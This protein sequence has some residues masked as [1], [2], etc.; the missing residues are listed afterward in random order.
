MRYSVY[1]QYQ[2]KEPLLVEASDSLSAQKA[3]LDMLDGVRETRLIEQVSD[4]E[5]IV[6]SVIAT[7]QYT[8]GLSAVKSGEG[9]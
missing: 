8:I 6:E 2:R 1:V 3:A 9:E 7:N 4:N 5:R